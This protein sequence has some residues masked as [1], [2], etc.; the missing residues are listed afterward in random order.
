MYHIKIR[1]KLKKT[2]DHVTKQLENGPGTQKILPDIS[3][4][5]TDVLFTKEVSTTELRVQ[6]DQPLFNQNT[7]YPKT[8]MSLESCTGDD[9]DTEPAQTTIPT[10]VLDNED[11]RL[12]VAAIL[13]KGMQHTVCIRGS[14]KIISR[15]HFNVVDIWRPGES[16]AIQ[17]RRSVTIKSRTKIYLRQIFHFNRN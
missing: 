14:F 6:D 10:E 3:M 12:E 5:D 15:L 7:T 17:T 4:T 8:L 1:S 2:V 9:G 13:F 11:N 16:I